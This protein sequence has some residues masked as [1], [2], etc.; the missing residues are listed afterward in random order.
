[1]S[2]FCGKQPSSRISKTQNLQWT[3]TGILV[4]TNFVPQ[5]YQI[6]VATQIAGWMAVD[7]LGT[8]PTA[9]GGLGTWPPTRSL[10]RRLFVAV[11]ESAFGRKR[12][13]QPFRSLSAFLNPPVSPA[14]VSF[15]LSQGRASH[16][17]L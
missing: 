2:N 12:T 16:Y 5:T 6:R 13:S 7:N 8:V 15:D 11:H 4:S 10:N 3:G 17:L 1:V 14:G 9:A